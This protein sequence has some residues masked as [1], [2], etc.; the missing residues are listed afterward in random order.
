VTPR[1]QPPPT[2]CLAMTVAQACDAL[3]I[4]YEIW[5]REVEPEIRLVRIGS[6]KLVPRVELERWLDAHALAADDK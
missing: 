4:S 5:K 2:P 1:R 3:S 6:R